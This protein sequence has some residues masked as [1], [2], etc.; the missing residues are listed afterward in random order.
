MLQGE[1]AEALV[2]VSPNPFQAKWR[3]NCT[4][5]NYSQCNF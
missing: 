5:P 2:V 3:T 4:I 1:N